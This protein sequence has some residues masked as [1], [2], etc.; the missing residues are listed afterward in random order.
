MEVKR[1]AYLRRSISGMQASTPAAHARAAHEAVGRVERAHAEVAASARTQRSPP[2]PPLSKSGT[3]PQAA[4][5]APSR[6]LRPLAPHT[7]LSAA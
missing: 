3:P 7:K 2:L 4:T 5:L 1:A 6:Q